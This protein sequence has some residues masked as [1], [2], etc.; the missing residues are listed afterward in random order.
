MTPPA[1]LEGERVTL[2][3]VTEDDVAFVARAM[4]DP[5]V[6]RGA[7]GANPVSDRTA[8]EFYENTLAAEEGVHCLAW[9]GDTRLGIASLTRSQYGPTESYRARSE[10]LAYWFASEHHGQGYGGDAA[11]TLVEYAFEDRNVRRLVAHAGDFNDASMGLLE[12]LGF[13]H[14][15]RMREAAWYRGDYYDMHVYG[16]LREDWRTENR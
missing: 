9:D 8:R 13:E 1:F 7:L 6:W 10:E 11:R 14:E 5:A 2:R 3:P 4:N 16:L 12:S 15:G